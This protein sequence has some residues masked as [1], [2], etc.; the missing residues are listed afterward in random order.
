MEEQLTTPNLD[1]G[2]EAKRLKQDVSVPEEG[3]LQPVEGEAKPPEVKPKKKRAPPKPKEEKKEAKAETKPEFEL[4][5]TAVNKILKASLPEGAIATKDAKSAFSKAA[6]IFVLYI[7]SC[8]NDMA[9]GQKR[10]TITAQ[11]IIA[12]LNELGY[13]AFL[14]HIEATLAKMKIE[15]AARKSQR[16]LQKK[17]PEPGST[18]EA[19]PSEVAE[20]EAVAQDIGDL[21]GEMLNEGE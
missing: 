10:Q 7:T 16:D 17:K 18:G 15:A 1:E 9:K 12:A 21:G 14:P 11:D 20:V 13:S 3:A 8:A 19:A 2:P 5:L 6:G 4:P